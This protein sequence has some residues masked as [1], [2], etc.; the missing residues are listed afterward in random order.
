MSTRNR[1]H[2]WILAAGQA[3]AVASAAQAGPEDYLGTYASGALR[4]ELRPSKTGLFGTLTIGDRECPISARGDGEG[5]SGA[6]EHG[7]TAFDFSAELDG[8][9]LVLSSGGATHRLD[10]LV[11]AE[12]PLAG[13]DSGDTAEG[14][15]RAELK[16]A[17]TEV[18]RHPLGAAV[19]H[20]VTWRAQSADG[21]I[22]MVPDDAAR[23]A[24]GPLEVYLLMA[25]PWDEGD[26]L[27]A[28][29]AKINQ[30]VVSSFSF[31]RNTGKAERIELPEG[32]EGAHFRYAGV[33]PVNVSVR[34][35][36]YATIR[37]GMIAGLLA[38][39][40]E[41]G[42]A[43]RAADARRVF[44]SVHVVPAARDAELAATWSR[45]EGMSDSIAGFSAAFAYTLDLRAD[46]LYTRSSQGAGGDMGV[47]FD[48]GED[49]ETGTWS[50]TDGVLTL[51]ARDGSVYQYSFRLIDGNLVL[52]TGNGNRQIWS[53]E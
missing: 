17:L 4:L 13:I 51:N 45:S 15:E 49:A 52:A 22:A 35:D 28:A 8:G 11:T 29:Q 53:R 41:Q 25:L 38:V 44:E 39:G 32:G 1:R 16:D 34:L 5:I 50:A 10:R 26:G 48:T 46:G 31:L 23:N 47:T 9:V 30:E 3:L 27:A 36:V 12:N 7:S 24:D 14:A 33:S 2:W 42:I 19:R 40:E 37:D 20:P 18:A 6:F 21:Q 43:R